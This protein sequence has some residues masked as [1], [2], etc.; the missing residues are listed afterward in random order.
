MVTTV[1]NVLGSGSSGG[2][3]SADDI[4]ETG[5]GTF[6]GSSNSV[7]ITIIDVGSTN[8]KFIPV[9]K[10]DNNVVGNVGEVT[11]EIVDSSTVKVYNSGAGSIDFDWT[12]VK[13]V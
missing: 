2:G 8:Y 11:V 1:N 3:I 6:A 13:G 5:T 9:A 12:V 10:G 4:L 7:T